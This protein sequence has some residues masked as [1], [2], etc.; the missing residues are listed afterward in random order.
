MTLKNLNKMVHQLIDEFQRYRMGK[1]TFRKTVSV[2]GV[3]Q[4]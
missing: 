2:G 1:I 3:N 4:E